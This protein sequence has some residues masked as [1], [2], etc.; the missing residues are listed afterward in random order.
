M[1]ILWRLL[2]VFTFLLSAC[3]PQF[4]KT[5]YALSPYPLQG[6]APQAD[7][8]SLDNS[9]QPPD[10]DSEN[11]IVEK[12]M[13]YLSIF[14]NTS[15]NEIK[16]LGVEKKEWANA[17]L[18]VQNPD[19]S[20]AEIIVHGYLIKAQVVERFIEVHTNQDGTS[21]RFAGENQVKDIEERVKDYLMETLGT[22]REE[23]Y[24]LDIQEVEWNDSC[25]G[26]SKPDQMCLQVITPGYRIIVEAQ[27]KK[28][29]LHTD[30]EGK[31]IV[32]ARR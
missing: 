19:E 13:E 18:E 11:R 3:Q 24:I 14:L 28:L 23:I 6:D 9:Y 4:S 25:L 5:P 10:E 31:R 27:G 17:C 30:R 8:P 7:Y 29:V 12:V 2:L 1:R 16:I 21:I 32:E 20:C 26:V 15:K 22:P